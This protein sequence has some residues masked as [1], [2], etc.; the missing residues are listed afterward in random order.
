MDGIF[1]DVNSD[2]ILKILHLFGD[3]V[4]TQ[5]AHICKLFARII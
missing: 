1:E 5:N 2:I 3:F 4:L